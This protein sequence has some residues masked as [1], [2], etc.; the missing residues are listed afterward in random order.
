MVSNAF[1]NPYKSPRSERF[2]RKKSDVR[3]CAFVEKNLFYLPTGFYLQLFYS[4]LFLLS[5]W[6]SSPGTAQENPENC[7]VTERCV[8]TCTHP[9]TQRAGFVSA[10]LPPYFFSK[11]RLNLTWRY[12]WWLTPCVGFLPPGLASIF[13][14]MCMALAQLIRRGG[15]MS[16]A[17]R[18]NC[19]KEGIN[20]PHSLTNYISSPPGSFMKEITGLPLL[21]QVNLLLLST[22]TLL[23]FQLPV[24]SA[25]SESSSTFSWQS[26]F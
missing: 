14:G 15:G 11:G 16:S 4:S 17:T 9:Q 18:K 1:V 5:Q 25:C 26:G 23:T 24:P 2:G 3:F 20:M 13:R 12:V 19:C 7:N 8:H 6:H 21:P 10:P 22:C